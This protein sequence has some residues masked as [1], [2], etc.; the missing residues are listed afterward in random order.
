VEGA[1]ASEDCLTNGKPDV[2]KIRPMIYDID[3]RRYL[4]FGDVIAQAF[5]VGLELKKRL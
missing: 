2:E 5:K 1:Y 4:A 3:F